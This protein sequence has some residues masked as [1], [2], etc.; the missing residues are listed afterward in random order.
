MRFADG[1]GC[2]C[3]GTYGSLEVPYTCHALLSFDVGVTL[4][5]R[6]SA[7]GP[8]NCPTTLAASI[9]TIEQ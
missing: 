2:G 4:T 6:K 8:H 3:V 5:A 7:F 1:Q 9:H